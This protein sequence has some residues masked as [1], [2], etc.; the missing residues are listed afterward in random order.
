MLKTHDGLRLYD[1]VGMLRRKVPSIHHNPCDLFVVG[2]EKATSEVCT[3]VFL[4]QLGKSHV[5]SHS[6]VK[7]ELGRPFLYDTIQ[8][9]CLTKGC[10]L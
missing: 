8:I 3:K 6:S 9:I 7:A 2:S 5:A 4:Y 10:C 1:A